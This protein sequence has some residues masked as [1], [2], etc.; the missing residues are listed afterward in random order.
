M[1]LFSSVLLN[2]ASLGLMLV[3]FLVKLQRTQRDLLLPMYPQSA[4]QL[5][6]MKIR[7]LYVTSAQQE[8]KHL[9]IANPVFSINP[10]K[11]HVSHCE[12]NYLYPNPIQAPK[13][14]VTAAD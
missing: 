9:S 3:L 6:R 4:H 7:K 5:G 10:K 12:E 8:Q 1:K 14:A 2:Q 11:P 13:A